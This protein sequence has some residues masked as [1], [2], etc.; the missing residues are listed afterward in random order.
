[1]A[2]SSLFNINSTLPDLDELLQC[3][4]A[5]YTTHTASAALVRKPG[6]HQ[7]NPI[8]VLDTPPPL[9]QVTLAAWREGSQA[10]SAPS[11][12]RRPWYTGVESSAQA[13]AQ[14]SFSPLPPPRT[15]TPNGHKYCAAST[16]LVHNINDPLPLW[17]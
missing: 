16:S 1:M 11:W 4:P 3:R 15:P 6:D 9:H 10:P 17:L 7:S 8:E 5:A 13:S 12:L 2:D 14:E